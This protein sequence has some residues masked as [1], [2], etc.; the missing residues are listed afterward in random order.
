MT[1]GARLSVDIGGTFTDLVL[2]GADGDIATLKVSSTPAAPED[3]VLT[4]VVQLL[5]VAG[6]SP[7]AS[8]SKA[9]E[10]SSPTETRG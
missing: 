1:S 7:S 4:G 5:G 2:L 6:I 9:L 10:A 8:P 3:A